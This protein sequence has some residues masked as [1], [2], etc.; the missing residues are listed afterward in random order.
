LFTLGESNTKQKKFR[1]IVYRVC[2]IGMLVD[3]AL[4]LIPVRFF[5]K[6]FIIEAV[7]L[8]FFGVS[9][10]VKGQVFGLFSDKE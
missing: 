8:T 10:L 4:M 5:A 6:T 3:L 1:N 2:G 7:A 9:W